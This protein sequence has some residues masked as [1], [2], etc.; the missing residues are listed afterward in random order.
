MDLRTLRQVDFRKHDC[1]TSPGLRRDA[2]PAPYFG[3]HREGV[4][5]LRRACPR[6]TLL[7]AWQVWPVRAD[8]W[9]SAWPCR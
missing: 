5:P 1:R 2:R 9:Q 6:A 8:G 4:H 7:I 3:C